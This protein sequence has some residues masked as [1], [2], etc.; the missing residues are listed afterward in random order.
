MHVY[1]CGEGKKMCI[2][3]IVLLK[4][5]PVPGPLAGRSVVAAGTAV[6]GDHLFGQRRPFDIQPGRWARLACRPALAQCVMQQ[7]A[8]SGA[9]SPTAVKWNSADVIYAYLRRHFFFAQ[10]KRTITYKYRLLDIFG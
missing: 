6:N 8:A 4:A 1:V 3:V 10:T 7:S 5:S 9:K 2:S